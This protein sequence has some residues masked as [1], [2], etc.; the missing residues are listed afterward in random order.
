MCPLPDTTIGLTVAQRNDTRSVPGREANRLLAAV[1][2]NELSRLEPHL[3]P[4]RE[5]KAKL[6]FND[7][8]DESHGQP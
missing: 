3:Q 2:A 7:L 4:G 5:L 6:A 1:P 8:W